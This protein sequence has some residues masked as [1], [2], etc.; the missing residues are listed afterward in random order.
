MYSLSKAYGFAGWRIGYMVYPEHLAAAVAKS[1]DTILIC[2]P[3]V[4]QVAALAALRVGRAHCEPHV[5]EFAR[6]RDIVVEQ[7]S[8]LAPLAEVPA[9]D[10]ALYCMLKVRTRLD[11]MTLTERLIR[12]HRVAVIPGPAFGLTDG[13]SFRVAFGALQRDTVEEGIGRLVAGI[14]TIVGL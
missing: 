11:P 10:G 5:R 12:E 9:A 8:A 14:R 6:I 3:V 7:L 4:S 1:Q 2:P 13:C